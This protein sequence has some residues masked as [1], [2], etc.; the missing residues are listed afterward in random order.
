ML[1]PYARHFIFCLALVQPSKTGNGLNMTEILLTGR[2]SI[3][4]HTNTSICLISQWHQIEQLL[5]LQQHKPNI[6]IPTNGI[7]FFVSFFLNSQHNEIWYFY[8]LGNQQKH[9]RAWK[10][11]TASSTV[12]YKQDVSA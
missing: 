1:C 3:K 5:I 8:C 2:Y 10:P 12:N 4:K 7:F 11:L 6:D 9:S